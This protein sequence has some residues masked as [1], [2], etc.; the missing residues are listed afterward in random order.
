MTVRRRNMDKVGLKI[1]KHWNRLVASIEVEDEEYYDEAV[2][3]F[4]M[5]HHRCVI[6]Y[7]MSIPVNQHNIISR[8]GKNL[9]VSAKIISYHQT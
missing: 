6:K 4:K 9:H 8:K 5:A 3:W 2:D 1:P 7:K